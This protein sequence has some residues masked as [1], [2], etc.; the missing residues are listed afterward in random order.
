MHF[1]DILL[2][3]VMTEAAAKTTVLIRIYMDYAQTPKV[4]YCAA[5]LARYKV[6]IET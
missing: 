6:I 1:A 2:V 5:I 4:V 3:Y